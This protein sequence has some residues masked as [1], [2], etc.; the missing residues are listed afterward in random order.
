MLRMKGG[1]VLALAML[2]CQGS[3]TVDYQ[4]LKEFQTWLWDGS[5]EGQG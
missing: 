1:G 5:R 2:L 4:N 3:Y